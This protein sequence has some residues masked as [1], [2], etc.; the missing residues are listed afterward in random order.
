MKQSG[1]L[2]KGEW[3]SKKP[4]V[5]WNRMPPARAKNLPLSYVAAMA[6]RRARLGPY[7]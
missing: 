6:W 7:I 5:Y 3:K 4:K 1:H 2:I